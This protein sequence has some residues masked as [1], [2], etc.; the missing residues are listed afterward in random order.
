LLPRLTTNGFKNDFYHLLADKIHQ[1][2]D[3]KILKCALKDDQKGVGEA[4]ALG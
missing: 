4:Y 3:Y 2:N 1:I